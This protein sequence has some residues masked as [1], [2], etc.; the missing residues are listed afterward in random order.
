M[1]ASTI[2]IGANPNVVGSLKFE[3]SNDIGPQIEITLT[4]VQFGPGGA[5]NLI[6]DDWGLINLEGRV[7]FTGGSFGTV[8][9][10]DDAATSPNVG[11][12]YIGNGLVSWQPEG[13][14]G[15]VPLGNCNSF[16]FEQTA[17]R[18]EHWEHMSGTRSMDYSPI[19]QQSATIRLQLDEW[20]AA[21]L[22]MYMLDA[23]AVVT[24]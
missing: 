18:L 19:N 15:F 12:Y 1:A 7:L 11:N 14:T 20:T 5:L 10:P 22:R 16:E 6:G 17:E 13:D 4:K 24:P 2:N 3:G 8:T 9:H 21:N 23:A